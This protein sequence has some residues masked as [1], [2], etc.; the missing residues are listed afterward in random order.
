MQNHTLTVQVPADTARA[1]ETA[2][3]EERRRVDD[4][5]RR[6]LRELMKTLPAAVG[7]RSA[8]SQAG[9]NHP[10]AEIHP[11]VLAISALVPPDIDA[12]AEYRDYLM[13]KHR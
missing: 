5:L 10:N 13:K 2:S 6:R 12:R 3:P 11:D 8:T 4:A 9:R 7:D 1:Y